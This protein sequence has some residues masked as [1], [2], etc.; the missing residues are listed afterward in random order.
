LRASLSRF[1][2][3]LRFGLSVALVAFILHKIELAAMGRVLASARPE[4]VVVALIAIF[5]ERVVMAWKWRLLLAAKG[6]RVSLPRVLKIVYLSN[7]IGA[8]LPSSLGVDAV[9]SYSLYRHGTA[10]SESVSSMLVDKVLALAAMIAVPVMVVVFMPGALFDPAVRGAVLAIAAGFGAI[11]L[12]GLN[13]RLMHAVLSL[14]GRLPGVLS[15]PSIW[16]RAATLYGTFHGY[17]A[18]K[19]ALV[20]AFAGSLVFQGLRVLGVVAL[21]VSLGLDLGLAAYLVYVPLII[22]LTMLPI[23]VGGFGVREGAF[24]Y[25]FVGAGVPA[26]SA[27]AL[28]IL[29]YLVSLL[30]VL[31]GGVVYLSQGIGRR[32]NPSAKPE[33]EQPSRGEQDAEYQADPR[34]GEEAP[35]GTGRCG[36]VRSGHGA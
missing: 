14:G 36:H 28:S 1:S 29:L 23:S 9:R 21:G 22:M 33:P 18:H 17:M 12:V 15:A 16:R 27:L 7:F 13:R 35:L 6:L 4:L 20:A 11:L 32:E 31:P 2:L 30:S 10:L 25:F 5:L 34:Q 8:F 24:I 19:G 3:P 26:E